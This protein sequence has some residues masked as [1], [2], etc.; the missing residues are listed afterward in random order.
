LTRA[1]GNCKRMQRIRSLP[2]MDYG[3]A[4]YNRGIGR[5][6]LDSMAE[7]DKTRA[8]SMLQRRSRSSMLSWKIFFPSV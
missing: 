1:N 4:S 2:N 3:R 6:F 5:T 8:R 7:Y